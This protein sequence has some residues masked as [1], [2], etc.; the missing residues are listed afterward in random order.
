LHVLAVVLAITIVWQA[1]LRRSKPAQPEVTEW[2][3]LP[4]VSPRGNARRPPAGTPP[5]IAGLAEQPAR[6]QPVDVPL[7][8]PSTL[9]PAG[10]TEGPLVLGPQVGDGRV[11]VEPRP[12][13]PAELAA[14]LYGDTT[15]R[16]SVVMQRL[17]AVLD[18]LNRLIDEDQRAHRLPTWRTEVAGVP[19]GIDS[20]FITIAG[21]KIPTMA[22]ALLGNAL[23]PGN[24]EAALRA[25]EFAAMREDLMRAAARAETFRDFQQYVK[26]LRARKQAERD[27]A[28]RRPTPPDTTRVVP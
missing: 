16:D 8:V 14:R 23:P 15:G 13:L 2:L 12:A 24:Y 7:R 18:T 10:R 21:I 20:Q 4:P 26:E 9:G 17:H 1:P 25:R 19:F 3:V 6:S 5:H 11:W 22:L 28:R 27:A